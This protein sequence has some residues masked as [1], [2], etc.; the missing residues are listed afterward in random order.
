MELQELQVEM[1]DRFGL[2]PEP[3]RRLFRITALRLR[4]QC[5]GISKIE[6]TAATGKLHFAQSTAVDPRSIVSLVQQQPKVYKLTGPAQLQ[7]THNAEGADQRIDF[8]QQLLGLLR[9]A[10]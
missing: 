4:A 2:L 8:V 10:R 9:L 6:A 7:F 5:M 1:I 3:T